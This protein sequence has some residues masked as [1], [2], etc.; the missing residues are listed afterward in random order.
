MVLFAMIPVL[1]V[2]VRGISTPGLTIAQAY[3]SVTLIAIA[4]F[5]VVDIFLC[6]K[7]TYI[8]LWIGLLG[9]LMSGVAFVSG[10]L[11]A[12][13]FLSNTLESVDAVQPIAQTLLACIWLCYSSKCDWDFQYFWSLFLVLALPLF[14]V[15]SLYWALTGFGTPYLGFGHDKNEV[16]TSAVVVAILAYAGMTR[17]RPKAIQFKAYLALI[18]VSVLVLVATGS[19]SNQLLLAVAT[20]FNLAHRA[21]PRLARVHQFVFI[22]IVV[23]AMSIPTLYL[24]MASQSGNSRKTAAEASSESRSIYSGRQHIWPDLLS[25]MH[26]HWALGHGKRFAKRYKNMER[27]DFFLDSHNLYLGTIYQSGVVGLAIMISTLFLV[28]RTL[29]LQWND[30]V[31]ARISL[32]TLAGLLVQ[33]SLEC[34]LI[35]GGHVASLMYMTVL[36]IGL[37]PSTKNLA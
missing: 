36:G 11:N 18:A 29:A 17:F 27:E 14:L 8:T 21:F 5:L 26:G 32:C 25:E 7:K 24:E 2:P 31:Y 33:Q 6:P 12:V 35:Q 9:L 13:P 23:F 10:C 3:F 16:G 19:R 30:N 15:L 28:W 37:S 4:A 22:A 20:G 1:A 34:S